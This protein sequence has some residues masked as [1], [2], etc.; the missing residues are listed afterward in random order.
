MSVAQLDPQVENGMNFE[1]DEDTSGEHIGKTALEALFNEDD[2][3]FADMLLDDDDDDPVKVIV[4]D[5]AKT[6]PK[7]KAKTKTTIKRKRKS[8]LPDDVR[9]AFDQVIEALAFTSVY[10]NVPDAQAIFTGE[11]V[12]VDM[13]ADQKSFKGKWDKYES[14]YK[15][16]I[17]IINGY[18]Q[19][20]V[21]Q[22]QEEIAKNKPFAEIVGRIV[23]G[24][25]DRMSI[26]NPPKPKKGRTIR[27]VYTGESMDEPK[28]SKEQ[29][30]LVLRDSSGTYEG[31]YINV[32]GVQI[33]QLVSLLKFFYL[34]LHQTI[35]ESFTEEHYKMATIDQA[36]PELY[37]KLTVC[38]ADEPPHRWV[39]KKDVIKG[40]SFVANV[41]QARS[42]LEH[43]TQK[44]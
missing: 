10:Q 19:P 40:G 32:Q 36:W 18:M 34:Y 26:K 6:P 9:D 24:H 25:Y 31:Y 38:F 7:A 4:T 33:V 17:G 2:D 12:E 42:R 39:K 15:H 11:L 28:N 14:R 1:E 27:D 43:I 13:T 41:V 16:A 30:Y 29:R 22:A 44:T 3:V 21:E 23:H 5:T 20:L 37:A 8:E 35:V